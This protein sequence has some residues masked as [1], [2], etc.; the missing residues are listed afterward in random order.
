VK[1]QAG[2]LASDMSNHCL[3]ALVSAVD[4]HGATLTIVLRT[5]WNAG[6]ICQHSAVITGRR[7][8]VVTVP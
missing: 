6:V 4:P 1:R 3:I 7:S 8:S 5:R 2:S